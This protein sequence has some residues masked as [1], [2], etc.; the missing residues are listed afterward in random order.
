MDCFTAASDLKKMLVAHSNAETQVSVL[1]KL[2]YFK[3]TLFT[4]IVHMYCKI[5]TN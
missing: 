1:G 5:I 3:N 2:F 4:L